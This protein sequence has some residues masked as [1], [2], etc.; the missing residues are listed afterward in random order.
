MNLGQLQSDQSYTWSDRDAEENCCRSAQ[1]PP[2]AAAPTAPA[3]GDPARLTDRALQT[4]WQAGL[5]MRQRSWSRAQVLSVGE[6]PGLAATNGLRAAGGLRPNQGVSGQLSASPRALGGDLRDQSRTAAPPR[7]ALKSS[8][9]SCTFLAQR[10]ARC[11]I[12]RCAARQYA[13]RMARE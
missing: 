9:E 10:T 1:T 4:L 3:G 6:L 13:R 5:Q 2:G 8:N 11:G 12:G 7:D